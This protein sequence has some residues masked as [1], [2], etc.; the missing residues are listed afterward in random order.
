MIIYICLGMSS[1][2]FRSRI[3]HS[4][5]D[6]ENFR[7][8]NASKIEDIKSWTAKHVKDQGLIKSG[9]AS[10]ERIVA[11]VI[12]AV[13]DKLDAEWFFPNPHPKN[14]EFKSFVISQVQLELFLCHNEQFRQAF[15]RPIAPSEIEVSG[16][17]AYT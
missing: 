4:D 3:Y 8:E 1:R 17:D 7:R 11:A 9:V 15:S 6:V 14:E 12:K 13:G 10:D 5:P 2:I 16:R